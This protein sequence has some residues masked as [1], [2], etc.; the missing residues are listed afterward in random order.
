MRVPGW[1]ETVK[2]ENMDIIKKTEGKPVTDI[3]SEAQIDRKDVLPLVNPSRA[4]GGRG[5][6]ERTR[7][8]PNGSGTDDFHKDKVIKPR[9]RYE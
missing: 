7:G 5:V 2:A 4:Q 3:C 9:R 6:E 8:R 1:I